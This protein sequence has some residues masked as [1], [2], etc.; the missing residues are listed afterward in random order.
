MHHCRYSLLISGQMS[1][2]LG[3]GAEESGGYF[4]KLMQEYDGVIISGTYFAKYNLALK[5]K[6]IGAKPPL[7]IVVASSSNAPLCLPVM[8]TKS[9]A[10]VFKDRD[11]IVDQATEKN[12]HEMDIDIVVLDRMDLGLIL[13]H[14]GKRGLC[15]VL[16]DFRGGCNDFV[17][18]VREGLEEGLCQKLII[19]LLPVFEG[20]EASSIVGLDD[21]A[22]TRLSLRDLQAKVLNRSIVVDGYIF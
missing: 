11:A 3:K 17:K 20:K 13:D 15:N 8:T 19:E 2:Q 12:L 5:S 7:Q 16:V 9:E 4:S 10:I 6:E 14:C 1:N 18:V 21:L 22:E